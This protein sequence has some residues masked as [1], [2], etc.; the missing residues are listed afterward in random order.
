LLA[1]SLSLSLSL[2][3]SPSLPRYLALSQIFDSR[4][5]HCGGANQSPPDATAANSRAL[6]YIT[7]KNPKVV[8]AGNPGSLRPEMIGAFTLSTLRSELAQESKKAGS[9]EKLQALNCRMR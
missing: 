1:R 5:L 8:Y 2:S 3:L 4:T 7:F 9:S 6:F